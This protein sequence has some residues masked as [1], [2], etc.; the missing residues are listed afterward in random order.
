[1]NRFC[2]LTA[3]V[4]GL[5]LLTASCGDDDDTKQ[6]E[7][8]ARNETTFKAYLSNSAYSKLATLTGSGDTIVYKVLEKGTGRRVLFT[9]VVNVTYTGQLAVNDSIFD[10]TEGT[11]QESSGRTFSVASGTII[12][13]HLALQYMDIGDRWQIVVPNTMA[14]GEKGTK[15]IPPYSTLLF[16]MKVVSIAGE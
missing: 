11:Q 6:S 5:L 14:Y 16:D 3:F 4:F 15:Q 7:W 1:M 10:T 9:D 13:W 2:F 8:R 12:G